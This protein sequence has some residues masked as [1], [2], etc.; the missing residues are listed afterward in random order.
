MRLLLL[1]GIAAALAALA[2]AGAGEGGQQ[3]Q[4]ATV[5]RYVALGD[6]YTSGEGAFDYMAAATGRPERCH[7][8]RNAYSQLLAGGLLILV[9]ALA[10]R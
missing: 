10:R 4:A 9:G 3:A 8:S 2:F 6:S 1:A 7:R 5:K